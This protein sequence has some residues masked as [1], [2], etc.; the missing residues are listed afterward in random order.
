MSIDLRVFY[1]TENTF[2]LNETIKKEKERK[3][4]KGKR[5]Y[6]FDFIVADG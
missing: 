4:R 5:K 1:H 2:L 6:N 3:K